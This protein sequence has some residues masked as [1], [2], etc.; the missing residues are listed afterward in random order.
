MKKIQTV[1][2][3]LKEFQKR[4]DKEFSDGWFEALEH[5]KEEVYPL[6]EEAINNVRDTIFTEEELKKLKEEE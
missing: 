5:M 4:L 3:T 1:T 6:L 2:F